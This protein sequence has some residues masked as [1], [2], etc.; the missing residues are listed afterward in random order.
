ML[1][2]NSFSFD[3]DLASFSL[4]EERPFSDFFK[5]LDVCIARELPL[6]LYSLLLSVMDDTA[7]VDAAGSA[8]LVVSV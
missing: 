1:V 6:A 4:V 2:C 8:A 7:F 3:Y 5:L